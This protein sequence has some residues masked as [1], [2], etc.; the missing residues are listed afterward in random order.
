MHVHTERSVWYAINVTQ[1]IT[2]TTKLVT[3]LQ[4]LAEVQRGHSQSPQGRAALT[5]IP[6]PQLRQRS[7]P[8]APMPKVGQYSGPASLRLK[9]MSTGLPPVQPVGNVHDS[10]VLSA[11]AAAGRAAAQTD[12][13]L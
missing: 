4:R 3:A 12:S 1:L 9:A 7:L 8:H 5:E 11:W 13:A 6:M 10:L 2:H